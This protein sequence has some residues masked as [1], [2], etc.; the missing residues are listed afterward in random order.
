MEPERERHEQ[1]QTRGL[2]VASQPLSP[3][4]RMLATELEALQQV[5]T[6]LI[7]ARGMKALYD[8]TLD[9]ALT[10]LHADFASIQMVYPEPGTKGKLKLLGH[11]GL[12]AEAAERWAWVDQ[13]SRNTCGEALRTGRRVVVPDIRQCD[14]MAERGDLKPFLDAG[15]HAA[16]TLPLVSRSGALLGM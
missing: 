2:E 10:I 16:Q 7:T 14:F 4:Q 13:D 6:Q 1:G 15:I 3:T 9:A 8:Q 11:R 5:A 12:N